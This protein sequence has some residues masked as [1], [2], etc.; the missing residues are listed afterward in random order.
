MARR[1]GLEVRGDAG[2]RDH[3]VRAEVRSAS[4]PISVAGPEGNSGSP[5]SS[6]REGHPSGEASTFTKCMDFR[7]DFSE[8]T[9]IVS[10]PGGDLW[11]SM[12]YQSEHAVEV[13]AADDRTCHPEREI[14]LFKDGVKTRT[15]WAGPDGTCGS[16]VTA[17]KSSGSRRRA[18]RSTPSSSPAAAKANGVAEVP[19]E[20]P[21]PD[22]SNYQLALAARQEDEAVARDHGF[23]RWSLGVDTVEAPAG[24]HR[25]RRA[26]ARR[27]DQ[28]QGKRDFHPDRWQRQHRGADDQVALTMRP[29]SDSDSYPKRRKGT[30]CS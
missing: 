13:G 19:V 16:P 2:R 10:G 3:P 17:M 24:R 21:G 7:Q 6:G 20:V 25:H 12:Y 1:P 30:P 29:R 28:G 4:R 5:P 26:S 18:P 8:A 9:Q 22:G 15:R 14:T 11:F 23:R 27:R